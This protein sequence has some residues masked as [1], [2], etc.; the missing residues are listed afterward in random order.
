MAMSISFQVV[1]VLACAYAGWETASLQF[2]E[3]PTTQQSTQDVVSDGNKLTHY[4]KPKRQV[5]DPQPRNV[6]RADI[7]PK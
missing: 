4:E 5:E 7:A 3:L 2:V 1:M 6:Q